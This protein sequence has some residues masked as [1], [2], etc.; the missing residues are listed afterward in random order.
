MKEM[1]E[2]EHDSNLRISNLE[3]QLSMQSERAETLEQSY[4]SELDKSEKQVFLT[5]TYTL[6]YAYIQPKKYN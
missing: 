3:N 2:A 5:H 6:P 4:A 1:K